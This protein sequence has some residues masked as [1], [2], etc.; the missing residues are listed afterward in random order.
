MKNKEKLLASLAELIIVCASLLVGYTFA[1]YA[2]P[3]AQAFETNELAAKERNFLKKTDLNKTCILPDK[4][5]KYYVYA[6]NL[7]TQEK[8][9]L[10]CAEETW[11]QKA[12]ID[13]VNIDSPS[14]A[15]IIVQKA[16]HLSKK[17]ELTVGSTIV[18]TSTDVPIARKGIIKLNMENR[19]DNGWKVTL[20]HEL[21]HALGLCHVKDQKDIMFAYEG[22][23][24]KILKSDIVRVKAIHKQLTEMQK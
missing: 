14:K 12:K 21:G 24:Q 22:A 7:N 17:E 15:Q 6:K 18:N 3:K 11:Y 5:G 9:D 16:P 1:D 19:P 20:L 10:I 2:N 13:F 4:D 8:L 23:N